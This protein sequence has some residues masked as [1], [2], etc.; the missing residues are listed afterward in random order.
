MCPN[1]TTMHFTSKS[2]TFSLGYLWA[3]IP[4][5]NVLHPISKANIM[6]Q[7]RTYLF[8]ACTKQIHEKKSIRKCHKVNYDMFQHHVNI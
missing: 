4:R 7:Q 2:V 6:Q 3:R 5:P 1:F 8:C